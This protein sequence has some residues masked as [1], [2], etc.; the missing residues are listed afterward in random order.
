MK[1][2]DNLS[3]KTEIILGSKQLVSLALTFVVITFMAFIL[4]FFAGKKTERRNQVLGG[5]DSNQDLLAKLDKLENMSRNFMAK[6]RLTNI[7]KRKLSLDDYKTRV[8]KKEHK[9]ISK[10]KK[11]GVAKKRAKQRKNK[12][13]LALVRQKKIQQKQAK[14]QLKKHRQKIKGN[15]RRG[16]RV[17]KVAFKRM[18]QK[19]IRVSSN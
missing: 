1:N 10:S 12:M 2:L 18:N 5:V 19:N 13:N 11:S 16:K 8:Q 9:K 4:G 17:E 7:R 15:Y 14:L 3:E 6:R